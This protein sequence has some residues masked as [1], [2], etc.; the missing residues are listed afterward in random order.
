MHLEKL[1][2]HA[3][4]HFS[5]A[6]N[7]HPQT[8]QPLDGLRLLRQD[9]PSSFEASLYEP[10]LC[11]VLQGR[12]EV[13][14]G[15]LTMSF[16]RQECLLVSHDVPVSSR[17]TE[18]PYLALV[19]VVNLATVREL[20]AEVPAAAGDGEPTRAV[21]THQA[22]S[23]LVDALHRYLALADSPD[24]V[25]VLGPIIS[26]E[27]HYR[28]LV[29][30]F[31]GM[32]RS[33]FGHDGRVGAIARAIGHIR[34]DFRFPIAIPDLA[35]RVGMSPSSFHRH[36][37]TVTETT[38]LQYQ[39]ELRLLEARRLLRSSGASVTTAAFE[40]G[41]ESLSQFNREYSRKFGVAPSQDMGRAR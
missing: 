27:I 1:I 18:T 40:V 12:K 9:A 3:S 39:K 10:V 22:D 33:L 28:L 16:G 31:G 29:A 36:F 26:R 14:I 5:T 35:R 32:L 20:C 2:E 25:K 15:A 6:G 30:P 4:R 38:P 34:E 11:L 21:V 7:G 17:I 8:A 19:F 41:Y 23:G 24:D 37:K 13:A